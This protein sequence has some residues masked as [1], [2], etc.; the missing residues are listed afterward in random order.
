MIEDHCSLGG[1]GAVVLRY[2]NA[3]GADPAGGIGED[4][5]PETHLIPL[6]LKQ[7][8]AGQRPSITVYGR[9]FDT[10]DGTCVQATICNVSDIAQA[11]VAALESIKTSKVAAFNLG[12][13]SG[14][15][16]AEI[17]ETVRRVTGR[18]SPWTGLRRPGDPPTLVADPSKAN[19][20]LGWKP[21]LAEIETMIETA[22]RWTLKNV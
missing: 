7:A 19:A 18:D 1:I 3:A 17:V 11:H 15:S 10:P 13:G 2:F 21:R 5:D 12:T 20:V 22:W 6:V 14:S 8:A 9:D 4:H 16:V